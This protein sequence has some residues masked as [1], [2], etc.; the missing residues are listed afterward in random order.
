LAETCENLN[1]NN[2]IASQIK[3]MIDKSLYNNI[4]N[5]DIAL[6]LNISK[7]TAEI[8]FKETYNTSIHQYILMKK[9][10]LA[11]DFLKFSPDMKIHEIADNLG[12]CDQYHFSNSFKKQFGISPQ[13]YRRSINKQNENNCI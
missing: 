8:K 13:T 11:N 1:A 3:E 7:K 10:R 2:N 5:Y 6:K 12:F 9:M 4:S